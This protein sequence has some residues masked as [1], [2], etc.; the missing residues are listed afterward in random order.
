MG[1]VDQPHLHMYWK[2]QYR[3]P[4]VVEAFSRN[5]FHTLLRYFHIADPTPPGT[6]RDVTEKI[7]PLWDFCLAHFPEFFIPGEMLT[8]DDTMVRMKGKSLWET[9]IR[10]KPTPIGCKLT[11]IAAL[12][13]LL[14]FS[15]YKGKGGYAVKQ[16]VIHHTVT[17][18][19]TRWSGSNR[20]LFT[21]NLY[22]SPALCRHLLTMGIR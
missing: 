1:I 22:T 19:V 12:G 10:G 6:K 4:C 9:M 17:T 5:R 2:G 14:F 16:G 15:I 8:L 20:I 7:K 18:M 13:Y 11:T 21:D 3:Q